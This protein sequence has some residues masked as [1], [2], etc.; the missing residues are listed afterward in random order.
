MSSSKFPT[1]PHVFLSRRTP[2]YPLYHLA[3]FHSHERGYSCIKERLKK[4]L[5]D[6]AIKDN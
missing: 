2:L 3:C 4:G 6:G 1:F 5:R